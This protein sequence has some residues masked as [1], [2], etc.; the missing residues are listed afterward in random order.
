MIEFLL[1]PVVMLII[2]IVSVARVTRLITHDTWPPV[3]NHFRPWMTGKLRSWAELVVCPF[4][5]SLY[6]MLGQ[7]AWWW[8]L[9]EH[10]SHD[11]FVYGWLIPNLWPAAAY[12][13]A[14]IVAYDQPE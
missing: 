5:V 7:M 1:H 11:A 6:L 3:E 10:G 13:A 4:C 8:L 14:I 12:A 2:G 9:H